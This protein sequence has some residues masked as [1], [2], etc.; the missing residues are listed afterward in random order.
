[1]SAPAF[2][3]YSPS[4]IA[5]AARGLGARLPDIALGRWAAS[6]L[7]RAAG[8][9]SRRAFDVELFGGMRARLHPHDN[10]SEKR[11][12]ITPQFWERTERE[13]LAK[14]IE[15]HNGEEFRFADVGANA[16]LYTL[17][18]GACCAASRRRLRGLCIEASDAMLDRLAFNLAASGLRSLVTVATVAV[19]GREGET[20]FAVNV[21]NR[22]ESRATPKGDLVVRTRP[23]SAVLKDAGFVGLDALKI[24]I[25]GG[26]YETLAA[27]FA[28]TP[29]NSHPKIL[30]AELSHEPEDA[31]LAALFAAN[32]YLLKLR[33]KRNGV[34]ERVAQ[35]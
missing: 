20:R 29:T 32:G 33:T 10:I 23:L 26:E 3:A 27:Y 18:A 17:F 24:D 4:P 6:L 14:A 22:G 28:A 5:A 12:F 21:I 34:F 8:G 11:V 31:P 19:A 7:L 35:P 1:M 30:I 25:E 15:A 13:T 2:G 9:K 16:G